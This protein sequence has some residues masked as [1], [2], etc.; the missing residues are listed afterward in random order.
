MKTFYV[1]LL[2][3]QIY[4]PDTRGI[5]IV[6]CESLAHAQQVIDTLFINIDKTK[7]KELDSSLFN[8][9]DDN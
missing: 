5:F 3:D 1:S 2:E 6:E 8:F 7:I 4:Y 9:G